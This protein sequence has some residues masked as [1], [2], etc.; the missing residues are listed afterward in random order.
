M[1]DTTT[2]MIEA[3]AIHEH[4]HLMIEALATPR[5]Y[6]EGEA[7][8]KKHSEITWTMNLIYTEDGSG[9]ANDAAEWLS[10]AE[11]LIAEL[12]ELLIGE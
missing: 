4:R 5:S 10:K 12:K 11:K 2:D 1:C 7:I 3:N 6:A 9:Y 8:W